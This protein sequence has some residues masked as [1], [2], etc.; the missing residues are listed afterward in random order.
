MSAMKGKRLLQRTSSAV[1]PA[2]ELE[3]KWCVRGHAT[4]SWQTIE[5][6]QVDDTN[7][8][9][10]TASKTYWLNQLIWGTTH[11]EL[12]RTEAI[13]A[14]IAEVTRAWQ[15]E[16]QRVVQSDEQTK[17]EQAVESGSF[18]RKADS[19]DE[20]EPSS[21]VKAASKAIRPASAR[22]YKSLLSQKQ[23]ITV[24]LLS[25]HLFTL[26]NLYV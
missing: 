3:R 12:S 9:K 13:K 5:L 4:T 7:M 10:I 26:F 18:M 25:S 16:Y 11:V 6:E 15:A 1:V 23:L 20:D 19:S 24:T 14:M 22:K 8:L 17:I 2:I 21:P